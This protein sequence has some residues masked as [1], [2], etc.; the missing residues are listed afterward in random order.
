MILVLFL[1]CVLFYWI[2][3]IYLW[4]MFAKAVQVL[5]QSW[6]N[7]NRW[8][9]KQTLHYGG[10]WS[11]EVHSHWMLWLPRHWAC[12]F[13]SEG[14]LDSWS[15]M[16]IWFYCE[17]SMRLLQA[18]ENLWSFSYSSL[19]ERDGYDEVVLQWFCNNV[20]SLMVCCA[21]ESWN[22]GDFSSVFTNH[23]SLW[24]VV[25]FQTSG[26]KF[27][28]IDLSEGE[29]SEYDEKASVSVG[30]LNVEHKFVVTR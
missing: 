5:W 11:Q 10:Q 13:L 26:A 16:R 15:G 4:F 22:C 1:E 3:M 20:S 23:F 25:G 19:C 7:C 9:A 8:G 6:N 17:L 24:W 12:W 14:G 18:V 29:W 27:V 21:G 28:D 30:I 2:L